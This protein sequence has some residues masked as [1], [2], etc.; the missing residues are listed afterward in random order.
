MAGSAVGALKRR[1]S[2]AGVSVELLLEHERR[3]EH[4][5]FRCRAFHPR[6]AF[7][8]DR[9]RP[10]GRDRSCK[11]SRNRSARERYVPHPPERYGPLPA[12][13]RD[14]DRV[15]ARQRINVLVSTGRLAHPNTLPCAGCGHV[16]ADGER[17]HEYDHHEG[18][19]ADKHLVVE[20]V[21][22]TCHRARSE[23]RG[24]VPEKD[25]DARGRY[26]RQEVMA[27]G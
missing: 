14:G 4:W 21:C 6:S 10:D 18:Y 1:A 16:W 13:P 9:T 17:R 22:T 19:A 25:R 11:E 20:P 2:S 15:Q 24:E 26:V 8:D 3:G 23:E 5:C 27:N 7:G 12:P